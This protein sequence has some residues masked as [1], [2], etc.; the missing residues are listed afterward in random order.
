MDIVAQS[1]D[2]HASS[3]LQVSSDL[4]YFT[5]LTFL[6][7][8]VALIYVATKLSARSLAML[9]GV[10][11]LTLVAMW[12]SYS[13][14][15]VHVSHTNAHDLEHAKSEKNSE[16][17]QITTKQMWQH[18]NRSRIVLDNETKAD[19]AKKAAPEEIDLTEAEEPEQTRPAWVDQPPKR[20]GTV[21]RIVVSAGPY[22]DETECYHALEPLL[23]KAVKQRIEQLEPGSQV[24]ELEQLGLGVDYI[25]R[26]LCDQAWVEIIE[27]P[28]IGEMKQVHVQMQFGTAQ[29]KQLRTA[30]RDYQRQARVAKVGGIAGLGLGGLALL[31]GLLKIVPGREAAT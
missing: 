8:V 31:Y 25:L 22:K 16:S 19:K 2:A 1:A 21:Y 10:G 29:D 4:G 5:L 12:L 18:L 6:I 11:F 26:D 27:S 14:T 13:G 7:V 3:A 15:R 24:P 23:S 28:S 17:A 30:F 9:F 20:I